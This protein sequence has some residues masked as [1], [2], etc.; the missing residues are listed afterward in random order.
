MYS[1]HQNRVMSQGIKINSGYSQWKD[2]KKQ[3]LKSLTQEGFVKIIG[4]NFDQKI[5]EKT[6]LSQ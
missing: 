2:E 4:G 6:Q 5:Y 1:E 3:Y